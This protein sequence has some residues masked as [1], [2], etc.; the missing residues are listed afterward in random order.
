MDTHVASRG[1]AFRG[2]LVGVVAAMAIAILGVVSL[3]AEVLQAIIVKVNGD[4]L[5]KTDLEARQMATLRQRGEQVDPNDEAALKKALAD[6]TPQLL[7][8]SV[9]EMLLVQRG[10]E[11]GYRLGDDQFNAIVDNI[12]KENHIDTE[13]QWEQA[14]KQENV[15]MAELRAQLEKQLLIAR[16]EQN[17]IFDRVAVSDDEAKA[18]YDSHLAEFTTP[19]QVTLRE[20]LVAVPSSGGSVNVAADDAARAR[21]EALRQRVLAGTA[22]FETLAGSESDAPSKAN[23]GLIGPIP[24]SDL[25]AGIQ[26]LLKGMKP[27]DVSDVLR[28]DRGY[29]L[30]QLVSM[31]PAK[32][33]PFDQ[34]RAQ[35]SSRVFTKK[36]QDAFVKYLEK[37][38]SQ[39]IIEWKNDAM[40]QAYDQGLKEGD[41]ALVSQAT[42]GE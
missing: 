31:T 33:T 9:D 12:K 14:L 28:T 2:R 22:S 5:T 21:A 17:E 16:V 40:K 32:V 6:I 23:A 1:T 38:R 36:R 15:T 37:L 18:Y 29:Q 4:I 35:I 30:L 27:G 10:Q 19:P 26:T 7:V 3:K 13:A 24:V 41:K 34:A 25:S 11:L 42:A 8:Q 20:I 39:A